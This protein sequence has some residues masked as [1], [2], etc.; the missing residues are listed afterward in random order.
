MQ[1]Y[2]ILWNFAKFLGISFLQ[3]ISGK[4]LL[5]VRKWLKKVSLPK[6]DEYFIKL[7][8]FLNE[9]GKATNLTN[10]LLFFLWILIVSLQVFVIYL[11]HFQ[12]GCFYILHSYF[13]KYKQVERFNV[14]YG[15]ATASTKILSCFYCFIMMGND[16]TYLDMF[17]YNRL[18]FPIVLTYWFWIAA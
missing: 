16:V 14:L 2:Q 1:V 13:F 17:L 12:R 6:N 18:L 15:L 4:L 9:L 8:V 10:Q 11:S 5:D 7:E 3:S